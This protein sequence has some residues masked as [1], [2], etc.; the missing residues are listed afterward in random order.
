MPT[1]SK[2]TEKQKRF[3]EE[4]LVDFNASASYVRA[5]YNSKNPEVSAC[6]L[7]KKPYIQSYLSTLRKR[8]TQ[9]TEV[10]IERTLAEISRVAFSDV[11]KVLSFTDSSL[12]L[13]NSKTLPRDVTRAIE[14]VTFQES[15]SGE[16]G[17]TIKKSVKMHNKMAALN[18]LADYFGIKDDFN[19]ARAT[20]KRYGINMVEDLSSDVGWR[21][22][23][24]VA[25]SGATSG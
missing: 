25:N 21:L 4:Y 10:T 19:K 16:D 17:V 23:P 18:L 5:G 14:S 8:Q 13:E 11:T 6:I 22:E 7:L 15:S 12:T 20:F 2:I 24:Y 1:K 3:C 9:D